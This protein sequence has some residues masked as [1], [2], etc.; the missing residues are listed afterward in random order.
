MEQNRRTSAAL[1]RLA[2]AIF[3]AWFVDFDPVKAKAGGAASFPSM[4]QEVFDG[5]PG[6][7]VDSELGRVP[8]GWEVKGFGALSCFIL[9]GDWGKECRSLEFPDVAQI[10]RGADIPDL[11]NGGVG[12]MPTRYL[13][14]SNLSKRKLVVGF[15]SP[16]LYFKRLRMPENCQEKPGFS[17]L[18]HARSAVFWG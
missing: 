7:L 2:R 18:S 14:A 4:P 9:G 17:A 5:L 10:I 6:R 13:K 16:S 1:E 8:E 15:T 3:Q 11:Q 12:R